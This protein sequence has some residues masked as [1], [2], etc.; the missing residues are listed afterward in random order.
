MDA[1]PRRNA[2]FL[3]QQPQIAVMRV[4]G[5]LDAFA[6]AAVAHAQRRS[7]PASP[8]SD[9]EVPSGR[10]SS[11]PSHSVSQSLSG[12]ERRHRVDEIAV[13]ANF[14]AGPA[15]A[16]RAIGRG[17][18]QLPLDFGD[19]EKRR[20]RQAQLAQPQAQHGVAQ[21][22][23]KTQPVAPVQLMPLP[24]RRRA[25]SIARFGVDVVGGGA[26]P[27]RAVRERDRRIRPT[28]GQPRQ[29]FMTQEIAS[30]ARVGVA[31]IVDPDRALARA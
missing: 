30:Q 10:R 29:D 18:A 26:R 31:R 9:S 25:S 14:A 27:R 20:R 24:P 11:P 5:G 23:G 13:A 8:R 12:G 6:A 1:R 28:L 2:G 17:I 16:R 19:M 21:R 3:Q 22:I 4:P 7:E 15:H